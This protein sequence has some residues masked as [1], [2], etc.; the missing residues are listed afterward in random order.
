MPW[1]AQVGPSI[2]ICEI[3]LPGGA[4]AWRKKPYLSLPAVLEDLSKILIL[5][6]KLPFRFFGHSQGLI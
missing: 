6:E 2:E 1:Q 5:D 4:H 3:R